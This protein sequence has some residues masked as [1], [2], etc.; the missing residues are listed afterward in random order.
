VASWLPTAR[1]PH[2]LEELDWWRPTRLATALEEKD[3]EDPWSSYRYIVVDELEEE[4]AELVVSPW[5]RVDPLGRLHFGDEEESTHVTVDEGKFCSLLKRDR[6]PV[7]PRRPDEERKEKAPLDKARDEALR[8]RKLALGDV[9]AARVSPRFGR[10]TA[11]PA[12]WIQGDV[13]DITAVAR[14][15]AKGQTNA[16]LAGLLDDSHLSA[17]ADDLVEVEVEGESEDR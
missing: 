16:A 6:D 2:Q 15:V 4:A 5:P 8:T 11:D 7:T 1:S 3:K 13:Y 17:I 10:F 9:F 14:T 12:D